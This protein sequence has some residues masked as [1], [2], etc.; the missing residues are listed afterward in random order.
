[1]VTHNL[2]QAQRV[3]D[4][5]VFVD[6]GRIVERSDAVTFFRKP[7]SAEADAFL[8]GELPWH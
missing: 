4:E 8:K 3:G 6:R 1:M 7:A 5:V 2:G